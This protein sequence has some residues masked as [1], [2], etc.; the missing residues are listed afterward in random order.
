MEMGMGNVDD[1]ADEVY[2]GILDEMGLE[3]LEQDPVTFN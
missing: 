3:Y 1:Q 2:N